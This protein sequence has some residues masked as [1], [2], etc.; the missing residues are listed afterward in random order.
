M[1]EKKI[2]NRK[3]PAKK[4]N[5]NQKKRKKLNKQNNIRNLNTELS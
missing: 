3:H 2:Q 5:F 4:K 1:S